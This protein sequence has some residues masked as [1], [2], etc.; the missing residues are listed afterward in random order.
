MPEEPPRVDLL[1]DVGDV[2]A[3]AAASSTAAQELHEHDDHDAD[4]AA[5]GGDPLAAHRPPVLEVAAEPATAV[6]E[7]DHGRQVTA[8]PPSH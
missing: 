7:L 2:D 6:P 4:D 3:A 1:E 8:P 5:A